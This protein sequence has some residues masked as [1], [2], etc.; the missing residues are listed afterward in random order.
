MR[1]EY[2][3][4]LGIDNKDVREQIDMA[5]RFLYRLIDEKKITLIFRSDYKKRVAYHSPCHLDKLGWEIYSVGLLRMI[6]GVDLMILDSNC[7]GIGGSY[8]F[9]K[10][11]YDVSQKVGEP[12]FRQIEQVN[13]DFVATDCETCKWQI[14]MSTSARVKNPI[15]VIAEAL[16]VE[17]TYKANLK[18]Q[19]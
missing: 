5:T 13:P 19:R 7:C 9:K 2:P 16:D 17:A 18:N 1:D 14:E 12:L 11:N 8:G 10:E 4:L 15:S 6:E 3:H